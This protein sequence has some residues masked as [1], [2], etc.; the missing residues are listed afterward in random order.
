M[1]KWKRTKKEW[2]LDV[3]HLLLILA[4]LAYTF[5]AVICVDNGFY[6]GNVWDDLKAACLQ[7]GI[8][9]IFSF[10]GAVAFVL[11]G[12]AG[13]YD[14]CYHN[15]MSFLTPPSFLRIKES[16]YEKQAKEMMKLYYEKDIDFIHAYE[17]ER[18]NHIL[19]AL[20][21][22]EKQFK[23]IR[24]ELIKARAGKADTE[25]ELRKRAQG[26]LYL[27]EF[28]VD[29][30]KYEY[31]ERTYKDVNY[32]LNLYTALYDTRLCADVGYIMANY[33]VLDLKDDID[34]IDY[35]II[36]EE[37]NLL[38]GLEVGKILH[39]PIIA[40][41]H[42]ERIQKN[43]F[44]D[45]NYDRTKVNEVIIVHDVLVTGR[46]IYESME[47]LP[48]KSY[49]VR[50]LYCLFEYKHENYHPRK[51][52]NDHNIQNIKCLVETDENTLKAVYNGNQEVDD[53]EL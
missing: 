13:I 29:Q 30:T 5:Y 27:D 14:F 12:I 51:A 31:C 18:V 26:M 7:A 42:N 40:I 37:S 50:G 19:Q 52:L 6:S 1:K 4:I 33:I 20:G 22:E 46:H 35:I 3:V 8:N 34:D 28:I 38:L 16:N 43:E 47:K 11:F 53:D 17:E 45:G 21:I 9:E 41:R 24:Y 23:H 36:P 49:I 25:E 2:I 48:K 32:F 39:K 10:I 15:G 44:W